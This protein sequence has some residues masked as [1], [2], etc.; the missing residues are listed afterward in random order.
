MNSIYC[1]ILATETLAFDLILFYNA[2]FTL[3]GNSIFF[4]ESNSCLISS[5]VFPLCSSNYWIY[6]S[7][8][9]SWLTF[10]VYSGGSSYPKSSTRPA[11]YPPFLLFYTFK[12]ALYSIL[13]LYFAFYS[14]LIC[15]KSSILPLKWPLS[16]MDFLILPW[17]GCI[18]SFLW[19]LLFSF[20]GI[21]LSPLSSFFCFYLLVFLDL[22][23]RL[24]S[25]IEKKGKRL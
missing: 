22:S 23:L 16:C 3:S 21:L 4:I 6:N 14:S 18:P 2:S 25:I 7:T 11:N 19:L 9:F 12:D 24:H 1:P 8:I 20:S 5:F 15:W 13:F 10:A 17:I